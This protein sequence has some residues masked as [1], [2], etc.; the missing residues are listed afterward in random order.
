MCC[1][2]AAHVVVS[3]ADGDGFVT[4]GALGLWFG[5]RLPCVEGVLI[6]QVALD[7]PAVQQYSEL[8]N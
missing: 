6:I 5:S 7:A 4:K 3:A 2:E 1:V 8:G